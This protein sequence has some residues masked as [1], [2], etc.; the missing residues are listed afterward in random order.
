MKQ[1]TNAS[2]I[3]ALFMTFAFIACNDEMKT[4]EPAKEDDKSTETAAAPARDPASDATMVAPGVYKTL[5]DTLGLRI[6]EITV[7]PGESVP[8]H[9]HPDYSLYV[10]EGGTGEFT[11]ND[12]TKST[13]ELKAGMAII[14]P[15]ESHSAKN[16]GT[17]TMRIIVT[18]VYR[19]RN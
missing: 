7:K 16:T 3:L 6:L 5:S 12:G 8:V 13:Q 17:T 18:E 19:A 1:K 9:S 11:A 4:N 10:I 15:A 14:N 2:I